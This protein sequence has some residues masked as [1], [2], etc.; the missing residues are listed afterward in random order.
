[1]NKNYFFNTLKLFPNTPHLSASKSISLDIIDTII[2]PK[3]C[4]RKIKNLCKINTSVVTLKIYKC[5]NG[6][7]LR[8]L[9]SVFRNNLGY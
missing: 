6:Y 2:L 8:L 3:K 5:I 9:R 4:V 7:L 1:M